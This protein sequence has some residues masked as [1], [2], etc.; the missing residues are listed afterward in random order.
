MKPELTLGGDGLEP[1]GEAVGME[2]ADVD[3][4]NIRGNSGGLD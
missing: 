3:G 4:T 1:G 2:G